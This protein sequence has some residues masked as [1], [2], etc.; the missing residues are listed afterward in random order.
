MPRLLAP[1]PIT[2]VRRAAQSSGQGMVLMEGLLEIAPRVLPYSRRAA[3]LLER[4]GLERRSLKLSTLLAELSATPERGGA[5]A[6]PGIL[7]DKLAMALDDMFAR[8]LPAR[9]PAL[10]PPLAKLLLRLEELRAAI[11]G[12]ARVD[13]VHPRIARVA[14]DENPPAFFYS[15]GRG[16]D[17]VPSG[18]AVLLSDLSRPLSFLS[19]RGPMLDAE[20]RLYALERMKD[21]VLEPIAD[22]GARLLSMLSTGLVVRLAI[23]T[24]GGLRITLRDKAIAYEIGL[25]D[26]DAQAEPGQWLVLSPD[27][28]RDMVAALALRDDVTIAWASAEKLKTARAK[29]KDLRVRLTE[30]RDWLGLDGGVSVDD[31]D[32]VAVADVLRALREGRRYVMQAG[33]L[34]ALEDALADA[35]APVAASDAIHAATVMTLVDAG[36]HVD[37]TPAWRAAQQSIAQARLVDGEP[38]A[39][40]LATLRPY[41]KEGLRFLRRVVLWQTGGILADDMGLGKTLQAMAL[42]VERK[43]KGPALVLAPT[44]VCFNWAAELARFAPP[45]LGLRVLRYEGPGRKR[46]LAQ[47]L[48]D[49]SAAVFDNAG[50]GTLAP[51]A[52]EPRARRPSAAEIDV[53]VAS[54]A[55]A[56]RD[57]DVLAGVA[58]GTLVLDEAQQVKNASTARH[59]AVKAL[60][61]DAR[62]ALT[63]TPIE[64]HT[65]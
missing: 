11:L 59:K 13:E 3:R 51:A 19:V 28:A 7:V 31:A 27:R 12:S 23:V 21:I 47:A 44:S 4:M 43:H 41:Q 54:Y 60:K 25:E 20:S 58:W 49:P 40:F 16:L 2:L 52:S 48:G 24:G 29:A 53:V 62:I 42:L 57:A 64:N 61:A 26:E 34:V 46:A 30:R 15:E 56:Q 8:R 18:M 10:S 14:L 6:I 65:G 37:D 63:G 9:A 35:L 1:H 22:E 39:G 38:P 5:R 36:I 45:P 33:T 32:D 17:A 55:I 50:T